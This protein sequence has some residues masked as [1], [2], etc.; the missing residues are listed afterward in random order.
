MAG[1]LGSVL[2]ALPWPERTAVA[3]DVARWEEREEDPVD[4]ETIKSGFTPTLREDAVSGTAA[5]AAAVA[6]AVRVG[7][8]S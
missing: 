2:Q 7:L 4:D 3:A 5:A 1:C 8:P 6:G